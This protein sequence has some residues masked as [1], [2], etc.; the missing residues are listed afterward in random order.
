MVDPLDGNRVVGSFNNGDLTGRGYL[1]FANPTGK[2]L[3]VSLRPPSGME[4][5]G[6]VAVVDTTTWRVVRN[7]G[8]EDES[9]I[10]VD[11]TADGKHAFV[12]NGHHSNI[13]K[14]NIEGPPPEWEL[15][16]LTQ[17]GVGGPYGI[18]LNWDDTQLWAIEKGEGSHNRGHSIGLA[19]PIGMPRSWGSPGAWETGCIRG[20]HLTL[21]PD[22]ALNEMWLSCNSSFEVVVWDMVNRE[23]TARIPMPEGG[24]THSGSFVRYDPDFTG[25]LLSDHGGLHGSAFEAKLRIVAVTAQR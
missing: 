10:Y 19:D 9:P 17:A 15:V 11:F 22:P 3:F 20:D 12:S 16:G 8:T 5:D 23:V 21:H 7:I 24:S 4:T 18:R 25:E 6:G 1:A 13:A 14:I 2:Y